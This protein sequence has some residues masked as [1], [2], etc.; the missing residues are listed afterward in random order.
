MRRVYGDAAATAAAGGGGEGTRLV[1]KRDEAQHL[2]T[3][4]N[5]HQ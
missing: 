1:Q 3:V 2:H 5:S 4:K